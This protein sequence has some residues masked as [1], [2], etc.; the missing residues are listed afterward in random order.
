MSKD[1]TPESSPN[2][3]D[4]MIWQ[5]IMDAPRH[6]DD[7]GEGGGDGTTG[8]DDDWLNNQTSI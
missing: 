5:E 2:T 8:D 4:D 6:D 7:G 1:N 3:V